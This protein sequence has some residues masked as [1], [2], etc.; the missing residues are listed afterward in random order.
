MS[1]PESAQVKQQLR[2]WKERQAA[3]GQPDIEA[4]RR[5]MEE[6]MG[7]FPV[8]PYITIEPV[9]L[10]D[11]IPAEWVYAPEAA[12][13]RVLLY[14]HG[15]AYVLGSPRAYRDLT[16]RLSR[17]T[18]CRVL[19]VDYRLAPENRFPAAIEDAVASYRWL[20]SS[21]YAPNQ[22]VIGGDSAGG[23]LT[24]ATLLSLRDA[25]DPLPA[26]AVLLSPWTDL[27]GTGESLKTRREVE[28]WLNPD[29]LR[30]TAALYLGETDPR[31]PL[32]SPIH[33]DLRGLPPMLVHVGDEEI[34]LDDSL[35]L[36]RRAR[37]AGVEV[38]CKVFDGMWH[39]FHAFAAVVP[40]SRQAIEEIGAYVKG[41]LSS[42]TYAAA[43]PKR[44][45]FLMGAMGVR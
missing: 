11:R 39:V 44:K 22:V 7:Q 28:P 17:A 4:S 15:G 13:D 25:G 12:A 10:H 2:A 19:A 9:T 27:E 5:S 16:S 42:A 6:L 14:L 24:L 18:G 3:G 32:A 41:K 20:L 45:R 33:A 37:E 40:E 1:S 21:G 38:T 36:V 23:G 26:A 30:G 34:L 29:A 35:R 31:H 8:E 43:T